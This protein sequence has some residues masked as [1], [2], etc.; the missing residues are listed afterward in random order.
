MKPSLRLKQAMA[1]KL[2]RKIPL[3]V[4]NVEARAAGVAYQSYINGGSAAKVRAVF[5]SRLRA[6]SGGRMRPDDGI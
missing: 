2:L 3:E 1:A 6:G 5:L 4:S